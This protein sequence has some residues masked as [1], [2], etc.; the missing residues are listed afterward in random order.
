MSGCTYSLWCTQYGTYIEQ[1]LSDISKGHTA[2]WESVRA[3][4]C[5]TSRLNC[6]QKS[7]V[8]PS[9]PNRLWLVTLCRSHNQ[10]FA[11]LDIINV[12]VSNVDIFAWIP[13]I[14][15]GG[16]SNFKVEWKWRG[17]GKA[18]VGGRSIV[19]YLVFWIFRL[20][21]ACFGV[22]LE[23]KWCNN[24]YFKAKQCQLFAIL[25]LRIC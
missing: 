24:G 7:L 16:G 3:L 25:P 17:G 15:D 22:F 9:P 6:S 10:Y 14:C 18:T 21:M 13:R 4:I 2:F 11:P 19:F 20:A 5:I 23:A 8:S 12:L 1:L